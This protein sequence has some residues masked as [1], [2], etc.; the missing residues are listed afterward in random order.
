MQVEALKDT[1]AVTLVHVMAKHL[2][3]N[4]VMWRLRNCPIPRLTR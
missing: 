2:A 4:W 3:R 1:L